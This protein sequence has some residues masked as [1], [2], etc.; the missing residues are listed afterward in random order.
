MGIDGRRFGYTYETAANEE[1]LVLSF[2][3]QMLNKMGAEARELITTESDY[4]VF[5]R[6]SQLSD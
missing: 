3:L 6:P 5:K 1:Y 4:F 2:K